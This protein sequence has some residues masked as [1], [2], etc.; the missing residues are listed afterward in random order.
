MVISRFI[1]LQIMLT[2]CATA[3]AQ[4]YKCTIKGQ[5]VYADAPCAV[6]AKN[7]GALEDRVSSEQQLERLQQST[8][9][10]RQRNAIEAREEAD[11]QAQ[12]QVLAARAAQEAAQAATAERAKANRCSDAQ[13]EMRYNQQAQARYRDF[14]WQNSLSQ[15]ENEAKGLRETIDKDCR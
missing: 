5:V 15:R 1:V 12:R 7:V 9:E 13:R 14:G 3:T 8:K 6:N 4:A 2:M 10:R 11:Y